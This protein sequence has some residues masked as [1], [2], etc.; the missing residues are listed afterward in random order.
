MT[1]APSSIRTER[2]AMPASN[3]SIPF[4]PVPSSP[5]RTLRYRRGAAPFLLGAAAALTLSACGTSGTPTVS[6]SGSPAANPSAAAAGGSSS[7]AAA[8]GPAASGLI[9][10]VSGSTLQVQNAQ[11]GQVAVTWT[12]ATKFTQ[13]VTLSLGSIKAG[14]CVTAAATA[15]SPTAASFTATAV[16]VS[17]A[18]NGRCFGGFGGAVP[19]PGSSFQARPRPSGTPSFARPSGAARTGAF[20]TGSVVSVSSSTIV[21]ASRSFGPGA[22]ASPGASAGTT[23]NKTV[24]LT[25]ATKITTVRSATAAAATVGRCVTA[26]GK[27]DSTGAV[28]ATSI[29]VTDP[30]NGQ[31]T[32]G[33]GGFGAGGRRGQAATTGGTSA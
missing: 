3:R 1:A 6:P 14:D 28:A 22:G 15:G 31:C 2:L 5:S 20:A 12:A 13:Q 21:V 9:A 4:L 17:Q 19:S 25:S 23:T 27:A 7:R 18:V 29:A 32:S 30:V 26:Q 16:T 33:F 10:A 24:T 11:A 8:R